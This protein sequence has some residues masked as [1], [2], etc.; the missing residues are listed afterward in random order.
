MRTTYQINLLNIQ[1]TRLPEKQRRLIKN[2]ET[3]T[4]LKQKLTTRE[5]TSGKRYRLLS[6]IKIMYILI[7]ERK[8][9]NTMAK[10]RQV[11][12]CGTDMLVR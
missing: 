2:K 4:I 10:E 6:G 9:E 12:I 1:I 8:R 5:Q 3:M 7:I 11:T